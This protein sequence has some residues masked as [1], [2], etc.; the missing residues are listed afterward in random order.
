MSTGNLPSE[1]VILS[2]PMSF[3]GS[4][5]RIMQ[6]RGTSTGTALTAL[7]T[8]AILLILVAWLVVSV[9]YLVAYTVMILPTV[10]WRFHRRNVRKNKAEQLRHREMLESIAETADLE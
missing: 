1:Q 3:N 7:T 10:V 2:S 6:I 9:W 5:K 4:A 8:L